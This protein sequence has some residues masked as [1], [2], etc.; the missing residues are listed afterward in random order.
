V[1]CMCSVCFPAHAQFCSVYPGD[2]HRRSLSVRMSNWQERAQIRMKK[3]HGFELALTRF[4]RP[5]KLQQIKYN[6][7]LVT[8]GNPVQ[9][10]DLDLI[11]DDTRGN[12]F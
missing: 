11:F 4:V 2:V 12:K 7:T 3:L 9:G 8:T 5:V 10:M 1:G 6:M